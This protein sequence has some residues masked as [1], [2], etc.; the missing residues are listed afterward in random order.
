[1]PTEPGIT[2]TGDRMVY[3]CAS[4]SNP[5]VKFRCDLVANGGAGFCSCPDFRIRKQDALDDGAETWTRQ[6]TCKHL[7]K[8]ARHFMQ[9]L[10]RAMA[11]SEM[12]PPEK[13]HANSH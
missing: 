12:T 5:A 10:F 8:V 9:E 11:E 2:P 13:H 1:M 6:S 4:E 7:R 3:W